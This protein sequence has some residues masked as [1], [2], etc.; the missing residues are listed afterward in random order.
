MIGY[1]KVMQAKLVRSGNI[2]IDS[3]NSI[4]QRE[5]RVEMKVRE[6]GHGD[7]LSLEL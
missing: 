2:L 4:E 7:G 3:S 1:G 5:L 6:L